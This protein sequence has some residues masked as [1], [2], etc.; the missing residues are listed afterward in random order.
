MDALNAGRFQAGGLT[1]GAALGYA[2]DT[3][4]YNA[5]PAAGPWPSP[6]GAA[7]VGNA[8]LGYARDAAQYAGW[9]SG[10]AIPAPHSLPTSTGYSGGAAGQHLL[11]LST[12]GGTFSVTATSDTIEAIRVSA[13]GS[14]LTSAG[15]KPSWY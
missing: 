8:A 2:R 5:A 14:K 4:S 11:D 10:L 12:P 1:G 6:G 13:I 7:L 3:A 9:G 15:V